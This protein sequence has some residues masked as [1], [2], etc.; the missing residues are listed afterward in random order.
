M[1]KFCKAQTAKNCDINPHLIK[2]IVHSF[3]SYNL[4][5]VV[6]NTLSYGLDNHIPT[7][8]NRN[9]ITTEFELFLQSLFRDISHMPGNEINKVKTK[10]PST[11]EKYSNINVLHKQREII[12]DLAKRDDIILLKQDKGRGVVVI[13][14]SKYYEKCLEM[15]PTK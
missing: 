6:I 7:S 8:I 12:S 14:R 11:S 13:D 2:H 9:P 4:L 10:L 15:L 1:L 3:P 5:Q